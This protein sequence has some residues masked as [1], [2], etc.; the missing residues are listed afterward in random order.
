[1]LADC[2]GNISLILF[3]LSEKDIETFALRTIANIPGT[4]ATFF[5]T[6]RYETA[7]HIFMNGGC[8]HS[9][10]MIVQHILKPYQARSTIISDAL[11]LLHG[12][13]KPI[14]ELVEILEDICFKKY[15]EINNQKTR[16]KYEEIPEIEKRSCLALGT[17]LSSFQHDDTKKTR[18]IAN[19]FHMNL[20]NHRPSGNYDYKSVPFILNLFL[21]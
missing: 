15:D 10:K 21:F 5:E 2:V 17:L 18:K 11:L 4:N 19:K 14:P 3:R 16:Q 1:M 8:S 13:E 12:I 20:Y 9:Q 7:V 6:K